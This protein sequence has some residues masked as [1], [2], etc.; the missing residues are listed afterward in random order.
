MKKF[1][2]ED[3]FI[4]TRLDRWFKRKIHDVPQSFIEKNLRKGNIK[5][6]KKKIKVL[7]NYK[8]MTKFM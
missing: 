3:D 2:V 6:N 8:K 1:L 7:I 5:V 4:N